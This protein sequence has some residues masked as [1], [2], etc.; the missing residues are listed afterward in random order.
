MTSVFIKTFGCSLNQSDSER[1]LGLLKEADFE[2]SKTAEDSDLI[3]INTCTVKQPTQNKFFRYLESLKQLGRPI[4]I[5][6]CIPQTT[7]ELVEGYSLIGTHNTDEIVSVVEETINGNTVTLLTEN[8][9]DKLHLPK[10]RKNPVVEIVPISEGCLG[11]CSYCIVKRARGNL[12]SYE[13]EE[14]VKTIKNALNEGVKE[15]WLTAQ[16][17]GCYGKDIGTTLPA[18]LTEINEIDKHFYVRVGMMNIEHLKDFVEEL[19]KEYQSKKVFK[20]LHVPV[21]SGNNDILIAEVRTAIP[22]RTIST[23]IICGFPGESK[24]QFQ[25]SVN[26]IKQIRP[27]V[28]NISRFWPRPKTKAAEMEMV[29]GRETKER[30]SILATTFGWI[31]FENNKRWKGWK[32]EV[33]VDDHGKD[34]TWVARNYAY[35][36]VILTGKHQIGEEVV[37][38][39]ESTA[40]HDLRGS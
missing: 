8:K 12:N 13:P 2:L 5:A 39:I 36:P 38:R 9:C 35:K 18:L 11:S 25:D 22:D 26:L 14:I 7:P 19:M 4:I 15:I 27:D 28:L 6:G 29:S 16:D 10:I 20:F 3:I 21:Q 32:G 23:D 34:N 24:E 17:T 37:V 1:M 31:A 40:M 30:S 33:I